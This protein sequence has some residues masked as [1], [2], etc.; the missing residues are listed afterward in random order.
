MGGFLKIVGVAVGIVILLAM[1][2]GGSDRQSRT[3]ITRSSETANSNILKYSSNTP[4]LEIQSWRCHKE[5]SYVFVEGLVKNLAAEPLGNVLVVGIFKTS[6]G[7]FVK[8]ADALIDYNPVLPGQTSPFKAGTT[9]NPEIKNC[10]IEFKYLMGGTISFVNKKSQSSERQ[11]QTS[12]RR[13]QIKEAQ[14]LLDALGY[15]AGPVDGILGPTTAS[16]IEAFQRD[17]G[18]TANGEVDQALLNL[19]R[20]ENYFRNQPR[21]AQ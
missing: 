4:E 11:E 2:F 15:N 3:S 1:L 9:D 20:A 8:S 17:G 10:Y 13:E 19:L 12:E 5:Y 16:A 7:N 14:R 21:T 6:S 18:Y